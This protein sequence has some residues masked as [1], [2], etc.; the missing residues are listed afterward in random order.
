MKEL[1][2]LEPMQAQIDM[3]SGERL[4]LSGFWAVN[5]AK[6]KALSGEKLAEL[7]LLIESE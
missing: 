5:R 4:S 2:L 3:A 1:D 6:L 7:R